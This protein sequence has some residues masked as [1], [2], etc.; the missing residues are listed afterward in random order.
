MDLLER[1]SALDDLAAALAAGGGMVLV[2]GEAGIG[3]SAL[4]R[5][6]TRQRRSAARSLLGGC[7]PL[8]TP[9]A[10]GPLHDIA[11]QT[12][13]KLAE[14]LAAQAPREAVFSAFLGE[15]ESDRWQVVVVEDAHWADAATLDLLTLLG[16]RPEQLT[17]LL[18][19]TYRDDELGPDHPLHAVLGPLPHA[20]ARVRPAPPASRSTAGWPSPRSTSSP[21]MS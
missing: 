14:L 17:V 9:R 10:L 20:V 21:P 4:V 1:A 8:L 6:F 16:R 15:L 13:G 18:V 7:D 19:V 3:K 12:G 2:A 11:R 5:R